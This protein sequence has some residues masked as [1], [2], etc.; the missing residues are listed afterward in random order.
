MNLFDEMTGLLY[1]DGQLAADGDREVASHLSSCEECRRLLQALQ[2]EN[3]WLKAALVGEEDWLPASL[4]GAP[5]RT[6]AIPWGWIAALGTAAA[7]NYTLWSG[8]ID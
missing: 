5:G 8:M 6:G 3:I 4:A 2:K 1:L 7:G